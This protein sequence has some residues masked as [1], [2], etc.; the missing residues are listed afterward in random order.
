M[1]LEWK[2]GNSQT[3]HD[4]NQQPELHCVIKAPSRLRTLR[5]V[6][7]REGALITQC[8]SGCWF[9]SWYVCEFPAFHSN[10]ICSM[11]YKYN[12]FGGH[13]DTTIHTCADLRTHSPATS[14]DRC[15]CL[16]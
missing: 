12:V 7:R 14:A 11:H 4:S 15:S 13:R 1:K 2:A 5:K 8:S 10:F 9:E 6:L 3:Y 16:H